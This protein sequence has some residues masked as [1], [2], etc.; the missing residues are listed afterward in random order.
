VRVKRRGSQDRVEHARREDQLVLGFC[1]AGRGDPD[2]AAS[3]QAA[4]SPEHAAP[5]G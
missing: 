5:H 3:A 4:E 1:R 2:E